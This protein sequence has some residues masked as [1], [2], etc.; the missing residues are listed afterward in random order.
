MN[1]ILIRI[2]ITLIIILSALIYSRFI[3][4]KGLITHEIVIKDNIPTT[5]NG[6]KIVHFADIH[7]KKV[8]TEKEI[9]KLIKE[10]NN[11]KP[12]IVFFTGDLIDNDYKIKGKDIKFLIK[13]LSKIESKYGSYTVLGD[14]DKTNK[15]VINNIYLQSNFTIL[16]ND[17][18]IIQ[19]EKNEKI[20]I[21]GI[22]DIDKTNEVLSTSNDIPYKIVLT[23][24]PDNITKIL[25]T[26]P[27]INLILSSHSIN[28]S[29]NI[30]IIKRLFLPKNA[31]KYFKPH[32]KISNTNLYITNGI[33]VNNINFRLFNKPS[34]NFYR[35]KTNN[36]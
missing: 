31:K 22:N 20:L 7:Y 32:Y 14:Q 9:T 25:E 33:G 6:L 28:G 17:T 1:K 13:E 8:I 23:H 26:N 2:L 3:G 16:D 4:I 18:T 5:Y 30:P 29:I 12:D 24:E 11:I 36:C 27:N 19:N 21:L 35:L 10:I 15:E 34:I